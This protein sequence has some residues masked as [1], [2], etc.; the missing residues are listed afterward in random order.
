M[1]AF[2]KD[3]DSL[4]NATREEVEAAFN[5]AMSKNKR[6]YMQ[7]DDFASSEYI[8]VNQ[9][10]DAIQILSMFMN[11]S[12]LRAVTVIKKTKVG[13]DGFMI[14]LLY[15]FCTH[16][17]NESITNPENCRII[18][19]M[20]N[21]NWEQNMKNNLPECFKGI[22]F[23]RGKLKKAGLE[24]LRNATNTLFII[25][26]IDSGD[27]E[28][29]KLHQYLKESGILDIKHMDEHN[30]KFIFISA[31]PFKELYE[32]YQWGDNIHQSYKMTIPENYIGHNELMERGIIKEW[33]PMKSREDFEGWIQNDILEYYV[34][35]LPRVHI[36][37]ITKKNS[38]LLVNACI[39]KRVD[40]KNHTS[41]ERI[42]DDELEKLFE[43]KKQGDKHMVVIIK[44][45]FRRADLI[46]NKWK[47][48]I[49]ATHELFKKDPDVNVEI[50]ALPGRM[51]GYWKDIVDDG[52]KTGPHRTSCKVVINYEKMYND[53]FG[54][55]PYKSAGITK[56][57]KGNINITKNSLVAPVHVNITE[58][59]PL[60]RIR[61]KGSK[62][63]LI[64]KMTDEEKKN[65]TFKNEKIDCDGKN[66]VLEF[67]RKKDRETTYDDTYEM[68]V[69]MMDNDVKRSKWG[70]NSMRE[71]NA[72]STSTAIKDK[73]R[74]IVIIYVHENELLI[75]AW[76][77]AI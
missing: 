47:K 32:L 5:A 65:I 14:Y 69:W 39:S 53:P 52:H 74:N 61:V 28:D 45:L 2:N 43:P 13:A 22:I 76:N 27:K 64:I 31:T 50:Q 3:K 17:D 6:R 29:Q 23:H 46:P 58:T 51:S 7:G 44:G 25:D 42:S 33:Y 9:K 48:S 41:K 21:V 63:I 36:I 4:I 20:S 34:D 66:Y 15:L 11:S 62:P 54:D 38:D 75:N 73:N 68:H 12:S 1:A 49:G 77:G 60:P 30:N 16:P 19:G 8:Y 70:L 40:F 55:T 10:E 18:T 72:R 57:K 71:E 67:V 35:E 59:R 56:S 24:Q 37:R 26:E